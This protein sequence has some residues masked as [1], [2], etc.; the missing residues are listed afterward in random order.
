MSLMVMKR[1]MSEAV[2][3]GIIVC[4]KAMDFIEA[5]RV[6]FRELEKTE[7]GSFM[8]TLTS[9]KF[10]GNKSVREHIFKLVET[11]AKLKDLEVPVDD[12]FVVHMALTSLPSSFD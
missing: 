12:A 11:A 4:D 10:D 1:T 6:K 5:V 2:R 8:T 3:G 7:M 9:L